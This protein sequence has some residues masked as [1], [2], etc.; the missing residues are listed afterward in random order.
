MRA[1]QT[2]ADARP[3]RG[4]AR[5]ALGACARADPCPGG[6][7]GSPQA[8][9]TAGSKARRVEARRRLSQRK[10]AAG[11]RPT[12]TPGAGAQRPGGADERLVAV[13]ATPSVRHRVPSPIRVS[14]PRLM[15]SQRTGGL[16]SPCWRRGAVSPSRSSAAWISTESATA[17]R[18]NVDGL[19]EDPRP[20]VA[21]P[22]GGG[23]SASDRPRRLRSRRRRRVASASCR[24]SLGG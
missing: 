22:A 4:A 6:A 11:A 20:A 12:T 10:R 15:A 3:G 9:P 1:R 16:P 18:R 19:D 17:A 5:L 13:G 2:G 8:K 14:I 24:P 23:R 21:E 7:A